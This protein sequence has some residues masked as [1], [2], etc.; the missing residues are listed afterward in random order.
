M[1]RR[2]ALGILSGLPFAAKAVAQEATS[3]A[4]M[5]AQGYAGGLTASEQLAI[6]SKPIVEQAAATRMIF[7]DAEALTEIRNE[8]Y[9]E[10]RYVPVIDPDIAIMKSWS[11]MAKITFQ[12]QRNVERALAELQEERWD[13]PQRYVR[14]FTQR[15]N[16]LMW[17]K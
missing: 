14:A 10:N 8:L 17:G 1:N 16:K 11:D 13:R 5:G 9:A 6:P 12:R 4:G 3:R 15:L 2:G 7:G